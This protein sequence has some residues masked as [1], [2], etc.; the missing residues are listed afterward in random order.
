M[1]VFKTYLDN[2]DVEAAINA[3]DDKGQ[4]VLHYLCESGDNDCIMKLMGTVREMMKPSKIKSYVNKQDEEGN[5]ALHIA[6]KKGN[7]IIGS[8]L[9]IYGANPN[10]ENN[11][12]EVIN[13]RLDSSSEDVIKCGEEKKMRK[14]IKRLTQATNDSETYSVD[15]LDDIVTSSEDR[16]NVVTNF[17]KKAMGQQVGGNDNGN[18]NDDTDELLS[19]V[20]NSLTGGGRPKK[21]DADKKKPVKK[22]AKKSATKKSVTKDE[23]VSNDVNKTQTASDIHDE[24]IK[25]IRDL[26]YSDDEAKVIKAGLYKYTK[27]EHPDLN[28]Y[29]RALQMK[30]YVTKKHIA[31]IDII[32][33]KQAIE[34]HYENKQAKQK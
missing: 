27:T 17:F 1:N 10:L 21:E 7:N 32:A 13:V 18:D 2:N 11:N 15:N 33:L 12:H 25:M 8:M 29:K 23:P 6:S 34:M 26:G 5:T 16:G 3:V 19:R 30:E 9:E 24:V 4:T 28:A 22:T 20:N 31:D 14:L